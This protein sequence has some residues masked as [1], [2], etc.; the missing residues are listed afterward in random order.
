MCGGRERPAGREKTTPRASYTQGTPWTDGPPQ[1]L[2]TIVVSFF[3][4]FFSSLLRFCSCIL[5]FFPDWATQTE[6]WQS[7]ALCTIP[8]GV[9]NRASSI[10]FC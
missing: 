5:G 2:S 6:L 9:G 10:P 8:G 3:F 4:C 7:C 1:L